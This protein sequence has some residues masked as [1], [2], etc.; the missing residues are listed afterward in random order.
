MLQIDKAILATTK[1]TPA[2]IAT[3]ESQTGPFRQKLSIENNGATDVTYDLSFE[4][5]LSTGG[6]ITPDFW[7]SDASVSFSSSSVTVRAGKSVNVFATINPA[8]YPEYGQYGGYILITPRDGGQV[9]RVPFAGFVGDYQSIQ[10]LAPTI[11]DLPWLSVLY[12]GSFYQVTDP[13]DWTFTMQD[14]DLPYFLVHFDQQARTFRVEIFTTN[15]RPMHRAYNVEYM[16]RNSSVTGFYA[17][18][19]DGTTFEGNKIF[20]VPDGEYYAVISV[21][22]ANGNPGLDWETWTSPHFIIDRP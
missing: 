15:G 17:F 16:P 12:Q 9:Y 22:K 19:F 6:V 1:I 3:G 5:A 14:G 18:P 7:D 20:T 2:K 21:L 4:N 13:S 8:T 11:Y 10:V